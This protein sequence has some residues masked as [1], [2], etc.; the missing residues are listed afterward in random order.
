MVSPYGSFPLILAD[1]GHG[2][3]WHR[4]TAARPKMQSPFGTVE[5]SQSFPADG[6]EPQVAAIHTWDTKV[7]TDLA[8]VGGTGD[9]IKRFLEQ[10]NLHSRFEAILAEQLSEFTE[11]KGTHVP[12][13]DP[14]PVPSAHSDL[15]VCSVR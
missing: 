8:M 3:A 13:A 10:N 2:L 14:P 7:T 12:F 1:R 9:I 11:L 5:S 6:G 15:A 4:A